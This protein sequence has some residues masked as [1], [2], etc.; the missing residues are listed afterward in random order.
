MLGD[1]DAG[2]R[3]TLPALTLAEYVEHRPWHAGT[4]LAHFPLA[5][6][7]A[8]KQIT[9]RPKDMTDIAEIDRLGV[10]AERV[11]FYDKC[12]RAMELQVYARTAHA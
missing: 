11:T 5:L 1:A 4:Q 9:L 10:D 8:T 3:V 12:F 7:K 2:V 6:V